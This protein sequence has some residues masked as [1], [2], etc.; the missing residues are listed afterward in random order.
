M[1]MIKFHLIT[2]SINCR[3]QQEIW[4]QKIEIVPLPYTTKN[5]TQSWLKIQMQDLKL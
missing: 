1:I 4:M 3:G 5:Q 2:S